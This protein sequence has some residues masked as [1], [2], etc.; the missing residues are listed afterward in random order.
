MIESYL[1]P[2]IV[3]LMILG[4][5]SNIFLFYSILENL[6]ISNFHKKRIIRKAY[7]IAY[8][9]WFFVFIFG[10][11]I[12][13]IF[14]ISIVDFR[15]A[16]GVFLSYIAFEML[17]KESPSYLDIKDNKN[18][19]SIAITPLATPLLTGPGVMTT[20]IV[21]KTYYYD[22]ILLF[23]TFS[24]AFLVSYIIVYYG[25]II[26]E[27]LGKKNILII[28]KLMALLLLAI[29]IDFILSGLK[30]FITLV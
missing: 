1:G 6:N 7:I 15:I 11:S 5:F 13:Y 29:G 10:E 3:M 30:V 4:T 23:I 9:I 14:G 24:L 20:T 19:E 17:T 16:G 22:L 18:A 8:I 28:N 12:L 25:E 2:F 27:K 26:L 21:Y